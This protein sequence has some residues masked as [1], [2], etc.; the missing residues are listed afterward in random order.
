MFFQSFRFDLKD[1]VKERE[2]QD[3]YVLDIH[4]KENENSDSLQE[5]PN[6]SLDAKGL[7]FA[8]EASKSLLIQVHRDTKDTDFE[9]GCHLDGISTETNRFGGE[10]ATADFYQLRGIV[11][12]T[13]S[14][15]SGHFFSFVRRASDVKGEFVKCDDSRCFPVPS[16]DVTDEG[17]RVCILLFEER[18]KFNHGQL[19]L[20]QLHVDEHV[21]DGIIFPN[22]ALDKD[23]IKTLTDEQLVLQLHARGVGTMNTSR[24][25]HFSRATLRKKLLTTALLG[26]AAAITST[27]NHDPET[28]N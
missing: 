22:D 2:F 1:V 8:S 16:E 9:F 24:A 18:S 11:C 20:R 3:S 13:G 6:T 7:K 5:L 21:R 25:A 26:P 23:L 27:A 4:P 19:A 15:E 12:R 10:G 28:S 14:L 17:K